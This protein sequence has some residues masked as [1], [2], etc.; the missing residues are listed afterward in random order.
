M[1]KGTCGVS[2]IILS[3][4]I[5]A[6]SIVAIKN[7]G[8]PNSKFNLDYEFDTLIRSDLLVQVMSQ[9]FRND[10]ILPSYEQNK[11]AGETYYVIHPL[12]KHLSIIH[13]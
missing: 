6:G 9:Y 4:E 8:K 7:Y 13:L 1:K 11:Q 2:A 5:D 10:Y 3:S 12:L